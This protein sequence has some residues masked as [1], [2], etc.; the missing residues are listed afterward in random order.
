M[1][2]VTLPPLLALLV[3]ALSGWGCVPQMT[4]TRP[5]PVRIA[6]GPPLAWGLEP[7]KPRIN[8]TR[9][10]VY[11]VQPGDTLW[12]IAVV[13]DLD[14]ETLAGWNNLAN[15]DQL[16]V[17]QGL[18]VRKSDGLGFPVNIPSVNIPSA[19]TP[20]PEP[21]PAAAAQTQASAA[22]PIQTTQPPPPPG[23]DDNRWDQLK[24][25]RNTWVLKAGR[26]KQW[27]WPH[28]GRILATFGRRGAKHNNG[29]DIAGQV[30]DPVRATADGVVAYADDG[31][32]GYGNLIL[33]RH[34]GSYMSAY[35][36][37]SAVLVRRGQSVRAGETI[38]R[39]GQS[40]QVTSPRLHFEL[41]KR[42]KPLNPL[43]YLPSL[44]RGER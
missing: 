7:E 1:S 32:A 12:A 28:Q 31:L 16:F 39:L 5:A 27:L 9:S 20:E 36:H 29:I 42:I 13:H 3:L 11:V 40:G 21:A 44:K 15:A 8:R 17:G 23:D 30:G 14:P 6:S 4:A 25:S 26:P 19:K 35:A 2:R 10:D 34:G 22:R 43:K 41:R 38:A 24:R 33:L 18:R 37:N